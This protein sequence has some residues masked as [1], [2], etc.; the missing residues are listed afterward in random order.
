MQQLRVGNP[1]D[2]AI[3]IGSLVSK[4]QLERVKRLT[5]E[6]AKAGATLWQPQISLPET[7]LLLCSNSLPSMW[8]LPPFLLKKRFLDQ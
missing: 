7:G 5:T 4:I 1:L 6:G 8:I 2:K 3:D